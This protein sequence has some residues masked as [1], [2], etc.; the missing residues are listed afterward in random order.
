L[1]PTGLPELYVESR[2]LSSDKLF[3][4]PIFE[5][6]VESVRFSRGDVDDVVLFSRLLSIGHLLEM[7]RFLIGEFF[8]G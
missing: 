8:I 3:T 6:I 1:S 7:D 2:L 4:P 5:A